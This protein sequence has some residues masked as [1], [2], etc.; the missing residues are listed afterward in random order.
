ML[1][2]NLAIISLIDELIVLS[3]KCQKIKRKAHLKS[4]SSNCSNCFLSNN[5]QNW[6]PTDMEFFGPMPM[7]ILGSKKIP[8]SGISADIL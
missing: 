4:S 6:G 1:H 8:I 2:S 3:E 5:N 7:P